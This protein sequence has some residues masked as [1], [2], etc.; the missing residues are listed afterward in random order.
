MALAERGGGDRRV[1]HRDELRRTLAGARTQV[2][3]QRGSLVRPD[4]G[5][6]PVGTV[7][8]QTGAAVQRAEQR[9]D[10]DEGEDAAEDHDAGE[11]RRAT[12]QLNE[13]DDHSRARHRSERRP[14]GRDDRVRRIGDAERVGGDL[15][16]QNERHRPGETR[17]AGEGIVADQMGVN[18][19]ES[20]D[21]D[22]GGCQYPEPEDAAHGEIQLLASGHSS[23]IK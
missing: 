3:L 9:Q 5:E 14:G 2:V 12:S 13:R 20:D 10:R 18:L 15:E 4:D 22:D 23:T 16:D 19:P 6:D 11:D 1:E 21:N 7:P 8:V 17:G